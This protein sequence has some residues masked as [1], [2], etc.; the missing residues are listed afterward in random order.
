MENKNKKRNIIIAVSILLVIII[1]V[2]LVLILK[3][4]DAYRIIKVYEYGE[5]EAEEFLKL[6]KYIFEGWT[7]KVEI[8]QIENFRLNIELEVFDKAML[9]IFDEWSENGIFEEL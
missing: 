6:A 7:I 5:S 4:D 8:P 3:K 1:A 2:V 9:N